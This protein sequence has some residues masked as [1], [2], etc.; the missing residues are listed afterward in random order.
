VVAA[1]AA[2]GLDPPNRVVRFGD[3]PPGWVPGIPRDVRA[4]SRI[5]GRLDG[6]VIAAAPT[7]N[8]NYCEAF[9]D[10][11][12]DRGVAG[13]RVRAAYRDRRLGDFH[14]YLIGGML[15]G[16]R[17]RTAA[18]AGS[19][20]AGPRPRLYVLYVDGARERVPLIWVGRPIG[21]GFFYRSIP[22]EHLTGRRRAKALELRDGPRLV[23]REIIPL[24]RHS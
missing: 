13:C 24:V 16:S 20:L 9:W 5:V 8:G 22:K 15:L 19:T 1:A 11:R 18:I 6:H 12:G 21:A 3:L 10:R 23:A 4:D 7:R 14:S 17:T 2:A